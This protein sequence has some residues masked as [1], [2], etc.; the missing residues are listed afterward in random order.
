MDGVF[1]FF[2]CDPFHLAALKAGDAIQQG[3]HPERS[4]GPAVLLVFREMPI[5]E[6][7]PSLRSG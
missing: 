7:G 2:C 6:T 3:C 1:R 5:L 4:Q